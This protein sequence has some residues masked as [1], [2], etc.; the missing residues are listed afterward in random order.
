M[1]C[2]NQALIPLNL[3][4]EVTYTQTSTSLINSFLYF[5]NFI[6]QICFGKSC[7]LFYNIH[8]GFYFINF[9]E[10]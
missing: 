5:I 3:P 4:S 9:N 10:R 2:V 1:S 8:L 6:L 7:Y